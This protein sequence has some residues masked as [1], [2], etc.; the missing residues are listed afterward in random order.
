MS[1]SLVQQQF[2]ANAANYATSEVHASG[3]SLKRLLELTR[4]RANWRVLDIATGAGHTAAAFAPLVARV[5]AT[6]VTEEML[7][8]ARRLAERKGLTNIETAPAEAEHLPFADASFDLVTCRIAAHHFGD[9]AAFLAEVRRV[10]EPGGTFAFVDNLAPDRITTPELSDAELS[11]AADA[12]NAFEKLR[13]PSHARALT[14]AE[15]AERITSA[16]LV[17]EHQ[18]VLAKPMLFSAWC[19]NTSVPAATVPELSAR[20]R[21]DPGLR[22]FLKPQPADGDVLM[23]LR[24]LVLIARKPRGEDTSG[25]D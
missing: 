25:R 18:E 13:D 1:K 20:L 21:E 24:E 8:E 9:V 7:A 11:A 22:A 2:G 12:Y 3:A 6:D 14:V 19:R 17:I 23:Q 15:W 16:G 10:L 5:V 4:P